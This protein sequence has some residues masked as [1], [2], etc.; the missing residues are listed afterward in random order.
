M[1]S[2]ECGYELLPDIINCKHCGKFIGSAGHS[3]SALENLRAIVDR[4]GYRIK[5]LDE[6]T[7]EQTITLILDGDSFSNLPEVFLRENIGYRLSYIGL[8]GDGNM[9]VTFTKGEYIGMG[10]GY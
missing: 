2:C 9:Q 5:K 3:V 8:N 10:G 1:A 4:K 7:R 6:N